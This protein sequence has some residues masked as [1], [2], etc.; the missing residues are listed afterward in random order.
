MTRWGSRAFSPSK[1][2]P[3]HVEG[4]T[5]VSFLRKVDGFA[6]AKKEGDIGAAI[7]VVNSVLK[8]SVIDNI[9]TKTSKEVIV[10][11]V[12]DREGYSNNIIPLAYAGLISN[13]LNGTLVNKLT[14]FSQFSNTDAKMLE[15]L[16]NDIEFVGNVDLSAKD[17]VIVDDTW[18]IGGTVMALIEKVISLGGNIVSVTTLSTG[19][20]SKRIH[21]DE[22]QLI[23]LSSMLDLT[24]NEL[25]LT[26]AKAISQATGSELHA[27]I[28]SGKNAK[29]I[30]ENANK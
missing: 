14:K 30:L 16:S 5:S 20:Y 9:K 25:K 11:P 10:L 17:V 21:V 12:L 18:T 8:K 28:L 6:E 26:Y 19:R 13:E 15:R 4:S 22:D 23:K 2:S 7:Q 3:T 29:R 1:L 24:L 27:T